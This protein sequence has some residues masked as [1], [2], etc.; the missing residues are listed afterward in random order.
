VISA[1]KIK[2]D[3]TKKVLEAI[4]S[5]SFNN[6]L[7]GVPEKTADKGTDKRV[8][9]RG[10]KKIDNATLARIHEYG[11]P[12]SGIP[13]RPFLMPGI[14]NAQEGCANDLRAGAKET[15]D[16]M[17]PGAAR[18]A[19]NNAGLRAAREVQKMFTDNNWEPLKRPR[20]KKGR[21]YRDNNEK[22][23]NPLLDTGALRS[24]ITYEIR[25]GG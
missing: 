16:T 14:E 6:V 22:R 7:I 17:K 24:S 12:Q 3:N 4:D 19:L 2:I 20:S 10:G 11:A 5:L 13:P 15:L 8:E 21:S 25:Q 23:D 9:K 18:K 1:L